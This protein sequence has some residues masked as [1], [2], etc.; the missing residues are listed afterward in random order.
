MLVRRI[1]R[2]K[3]QYILNLPATIL[4]DFGWHKGDLIVIKILTR[5]ILQLTK[6]EE[7]VEKREK[8]R[9]SPGLEGEEIK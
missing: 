8:G 4:N 5:G 2:Q 9:P 3:S 7:E 1:Q 6:F